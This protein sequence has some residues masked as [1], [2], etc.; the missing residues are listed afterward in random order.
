MKRLLLPLIA[1]L[2]IPV[3]FSAEI[4][5]QNNNKSLDQYLKEASRFRNS[6]E[7]KAAMDA[8]EKALINDAYAFSADAFFCRGLT[9]ALA[10]NEEKIVRLFD[11]D[12]ELARADAW[13]YK[14]QL[15][16]RW[17]K[18]NVSVLKNDYVCYIKMKAAAAYGFGDYK[19]KRKYDGDLQSSYRRLAVKDFTSAIKRNPDNFD[20][21]YWR[22][23]VLFDYPVYSG[24]YAPNACNDIDKA[25]AGRHPETIEWV[26]ENIWF[27]RS[28]SCRRKFREDGTYNE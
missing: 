10:A 23:T 4:F 13:G 18:S 21:Y 3:A 14:P 16:T 15:S 19:C 27:L 22:G 2:L 17:I 11:Y 20:Y 1:A 28:A 24:S 5:N 25:Y 26:K 6:K 12:S 9:Y 7:Y 8:C